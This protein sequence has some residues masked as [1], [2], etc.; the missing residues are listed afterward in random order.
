MMDAREPFEKVEDFIDEA[1]ALDGNQ[2]AGLWL[3]AW[4]MRSSP[5]Q[6]RE[7]RAMFGAAAWWGRLKV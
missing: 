6:L 7:A 4:S 3:L 2:K 1:Q 5:V